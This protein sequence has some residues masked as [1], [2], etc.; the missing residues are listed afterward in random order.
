MFAKF[1][2]SIQLRNSL[3]SF[4]KNY[5]LLTDINSIKYSVLQISK[6]P[7][8]FVKQS[9]VYFPQILPTTV[10]MVDQSAARALLLLTT[11]SQK[12][13]ERTEKILRATT[14]SLSSVD[15][16][17]SEKQYSI[18]DTFYNID[19]DILLWKGVNFPSDEF[20]F[21]YQVVKTKIQKPFS[22]RGRNS[23]DM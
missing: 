18:I 17:F 22:T 11:L 3:R 1:R 15:E 10:F 16:N 4:Y 23:E 12:R 2:S 9:R 8:Q 6:H 14:I 5:G 7:L 19:G 20:H 21:I 13:Y